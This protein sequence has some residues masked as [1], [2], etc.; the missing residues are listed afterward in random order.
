MNDEDFEETNSGVKKK[1][2]IEDIAGF[3]REVEEAFKQEDD[4]SEDS[5]KKFDKW[6]PREDDSVEE[7]ER[8]TVEAASIDRKK[9]EDETGGLKEDVSKAGVDAVKASKKVVKAE[10]PDSEIREA[11]KSFFR[12]IVAGSVR[13]VRLIEEKIYSKLMVKF[14]PYF[15]DV[16]EFSADL[17][18]EKDGS[19][20]MDINV[21]DEKQR[22]TLKGQFR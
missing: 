18:C 10:S 17:R 14:N 22:N 3:A 21:P 12:P 20:S 8:K 1:G 2:D 11:S 15:F 13:S 7:I 5:L 9:V 6:R 4:V 16:K 19:Y